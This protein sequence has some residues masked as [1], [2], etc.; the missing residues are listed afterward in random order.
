MAIGITPEL[1]EGVCS[2][3]GAKKPQVRLVIDSESGK[4]AGIC[5][6]CAL[7]SKL[8]AE[9]ILEKYGVLSEKNK[10]ADVL[11]KEEW[12][13]KESEGSNLPGKNS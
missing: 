10:G 5:I 2:V 11:Q 1:E 8:S 7:P 3:C 9:E 13:K 6:E 4:T 12:L